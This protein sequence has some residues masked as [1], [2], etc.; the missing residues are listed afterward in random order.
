MKPVFAGWGSKASPD[1]RKIWKCSFELW[2]RCCDVGKVDNLLNAM[3]YTG[4]PLSK[5]LELKEANAEKIAAL[6]ATIKGAYADAER[7]SAEEL[8]SM[9]VSEQMKFQHAMDTARQTRAILE[10]SNLLY[11]P[12]GVQ[13]EALR[14]ISA[15]QKLC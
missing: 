9:P 7:I 5:V 15:L 2:K 10:D 13:E 8:L 1:R 11:A 4:L 3:N 14:R 12:L 6:K